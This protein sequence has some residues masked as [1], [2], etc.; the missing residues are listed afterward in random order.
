MNN[1]YIIK[2]S[3]TY[4]KQHKKLSQKDINLLDIVIKKLANGE[5]LE[6]KY[7]DHALS[8]NYKD[9]RDCHIKPDL[10]LHSELGL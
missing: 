9:F 1:K 8:G 10:I 4:K 2:Y 7:N 6:S 5:T 3:K